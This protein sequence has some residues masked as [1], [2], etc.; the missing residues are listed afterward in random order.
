VHPYAT[1]AYAKTLAHAGRPLLV[2]AWQT[3]VIGR[4][5]QQHTADAMGPYPLTCLPET[6]D[7]ED[8]LAHLRD[9]GLVSV[10]LVVDGLVGPSIDRLREVFE[11]ARPFKTHYLVD[12]SK[13]QPSKHHRY[14]IRRA[15]AHGVTVRAIDLS[16]ILDSWVELYGTLTSRRGLTGVQAF[17]RE[18]FQSL[19]DCQG[20]R[21]FGAFVGDDLV[22]CHL[23]AMHGEIVWSH[24]GA[25]SALGYSSGAA[26]AL[27]DH[28]IRSFEGKQ[29]NLGGAAGNAD[30]ADGLSRFKAGFANSTRTAYL[31]GAVLDPGRYDTLCKERPGAVGSTFFPAYRTPARSDR[32]TEVA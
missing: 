32:S 11:V 1:L 30:S 10:T 3:Y 26:Y 31:L 2:P 28:S 18:S 4:D 8:G 16:E 17:S 21:V 22:A 19:A 7:I 20:F 9:A 5:L 6:C 29:I 23:W 24:L 25:S 15:A 14:E 27:Y 13:Y 12:Q